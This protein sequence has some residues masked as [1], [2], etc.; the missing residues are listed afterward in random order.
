M[1]EPSTSLECENVEDREGAAREAVLPEVTADS[2]S[3]LRAEATAIAVEPLRWGRGN[4]V[5]ATGLAPLH[6][7]KVR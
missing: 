7:A 1:P 6:S 4:I 2:T 5:A 3:A